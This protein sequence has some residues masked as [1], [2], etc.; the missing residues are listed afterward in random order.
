M[1]RR[2]LYTILILY[3]IKEIKMNKFICIAS[4]IIAL[5]L[6]TSSYAG[7]STSSGEVTRVYSHNG[8]H[9][10]RTSLTD[11][12][13]TA[14]HFWWPTDDTDAKDMFS[15]ALSAL[16]SGKKIQVLFDPNSLDCRHGGSAKITHMGI[17][18]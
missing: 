10:I 16:M 1:P 2:L 5:L 8:A 4:T 3:Q 13:C 12:A 6:S 14:G 15:L 18:K 9:V 11:N 7:W 17:I